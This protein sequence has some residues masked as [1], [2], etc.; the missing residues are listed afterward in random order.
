[1][2]VNR[3]IGLL[4]V[5][6]TATLL[7]GCKYVSRIE[8]QLISPPKDTTQAEQELSLTW[9][10]E[11]YPD[12]YAV[13][14]ASDIDT[15][16]F[17]EV[18]S[19][20]YGE[21]DHLGRTTEAKGSLTF[22]NVAASYGVRQHFSKDADPSGWGI[23]EKIKIPYSNGKQYKGYFWNRSHLIGDALGGDAIRQNVITGTRTQNVGEGSG[24]MRYSE[25]KA[26]KWLEENHEGVLYYGAK[27]IYEGNELVPRY[28][29]VSMKSSDG[30]IDEKV[31]VFNT[32][33][34]FE[35]NYADGS[36]KA[37]Y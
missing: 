20:R 1:M 10:I 5:V 25:A 14:G 23:Q 22:E 26:Q 30:S 34:G 6:L 13:V 27:P 32:A 2:R 15:N 21:L 3:A 11:T 24:G 18:G 37:S 12:Y 16:S 36:F 8:S 28:V 31:I 33:N 35:I 9:N 17:P 29:E 19:I 4:G 7:I